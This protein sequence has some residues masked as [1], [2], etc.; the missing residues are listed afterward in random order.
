MEANQTDY[1]PDAN[2]ISRGKSCRTVLLFRL[3][4]EQFINSN[5]R[6][7]D[8]VRIR[9]SHEILPQNLIAAWL[10]HDQHSANTMNRG[11]LM[12]D[13]VRRGIRQLTD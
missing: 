8:S 1:W 2:W 7:S 12:R 10:I 6:G 5:P 11:Y 13:M 9:E 3:M 4:V